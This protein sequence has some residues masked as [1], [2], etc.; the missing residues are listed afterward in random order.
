[1]KKFL[2]RFQLALVSFALLLTFAMM[3]LLVTRYNWRWDATREK[4]YSLSE[5]TLKLL[6]KISAL[7]VDVAAFYPHDDPTRDQLEVFLKE[8][9]L[10]HPRFGFVFYDPDRQPRLAGKYRVKENFTVILK[11]QDREERVAKPTE[12]SFTNALL[13]LANPRDIRLCFVTGHGEAIMESEERNGLSGFTQG[14]KDKNYGVQEIILTRGKIPDTC[15]VVVV[16]GPHRDMDQAERDLLKAAFE[17]GKG[18][19]FLIDPMDP[20]AGESYITFLSQ[21]GVA[22]GRDVI[23]DKMSRLVGGDFLVPLVAQ[24]V[25]EHPITANFKTPTFFP[26]TRSVQPSTDD[27][28]GLEVIPL[29]FSGSGS[30]SETDLVNLEQGQAAFEAETDLAGPICMAAAAEKKNADAKLPAGRMVVV[31]DSDFI[32]NAY[33]DLSGNL[34]LALNMIQ[35][36]SKDDRF[37]SIHSREPEFKP[38]F[39][40]PRQRLLLLA[41]T[42]VA[43][44]IGFLFVGG[45]R[46]VLRKRSV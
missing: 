25:N 11:V 23:V 9:K 24:Y 10:H 14:L 28:P 21:F 37:I 31:G 20:Q 8:C 46:M 16:P 33:L 35:W 5:P 42:I 3:M 15:Q 38:L 6:A 17:A 45:L 34:D 36:L 19:F 30:W 43:I 27:H 1:M 40:K 2:I 13:K 39:L 26:V 7:P 41:V 4:I 32:A 29:A 44:P 12:E 22:V 18:I